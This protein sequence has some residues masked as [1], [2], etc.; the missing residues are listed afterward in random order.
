LLGVHGRAGIL[1]HSSNLMGDV[2]LGYR[3]QLLGCISLGERLGVMERQR[4]LLLSRPA[5]REFEDFMGRKS[6]TLEIR[7]A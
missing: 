6:F 4:C 2:S 3:A 1:I 5:V 7:D